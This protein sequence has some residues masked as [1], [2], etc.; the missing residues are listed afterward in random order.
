VGV[1]G[2]KKV[3]T[4]RGLWIHRDVSPLQTANPSNTAKDGLIAP[5]TS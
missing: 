2:S 5:G 1:G 3:G 4:L